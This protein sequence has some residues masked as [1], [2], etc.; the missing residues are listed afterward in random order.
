MP[1]ETQTCWD[2]F[3][4]DCFGLW[5]VRSEISNTFF[6]V[7]IDGLPDPV[8]SHT[9]PVSL[10]FWINYRTALRCSTLVSGN[11]A[12]NRCWVPCVYSPPHRNTCSTRNARSS[13][14]NTIITTRL[15]CLTTWLN[16]TSWQPTAR[17]RGTLDL[18][19]RHLLSL[20][21]TTL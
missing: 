6:S 18:H 10:K 14:E 11:C 15:S 9:E 20:I 17:A 5:S 2:N 21:L 19:Y 1:Y 3:L 16:L 7:T 4:M 8:A 12:W 13:T